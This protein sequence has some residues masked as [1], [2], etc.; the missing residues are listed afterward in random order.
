MEPNATKMMVSEYRLAETM[1]LKTTVL[2]AFLLLVFPPIP[3]ESSLLSP[4]YALLRIPQ[5][6]Y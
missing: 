3:S 6:N 5:S 4:Q 1:E 2:N